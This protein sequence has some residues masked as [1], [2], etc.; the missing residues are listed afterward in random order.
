ML[1]VSQAMHLEATV[2]SCT[3]SDVPLIFHHVAKAGGTSLRH[4]LVR[5]MSPFWTNPAHKAQFCYKNH[6]RGTAN[7]SECILVAEH[8]DVRGA[9]ELRW[10]PTLTRIARITMLRKPRSQF[11]S[12]WAYARDAAVKFHLPLNSNA[13]PGNASCGQAALIGLDLWA[14]AA[15]TRD[16]RGK[17]RPSGSLGYLHGWLGVAGAWRLCSNSQRR[18]SQRGTRP[19]DLRHRIVMCALDTLAQDFDVVG[20][21]EDQTTFLATLKQRF[22]YLRTIEIPHVNEGSSK[23]KTECEASLRLTRGAET[24]FETDPAVR[25]HEVLY[26]GAR[27]IADAQRLRLSSCARYV[28][29]SP[30][31]LQQQI[32][33]R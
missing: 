25:L 10:M 1:R 29:G 33:S 13:Q 24:A 15:G 26:A 5:A 7:L 31:R 14:Q 16:K 18:F 11:V 30:R 2:S 4:A 19:P 32:S 21:Y 23:Y 6:H 12:F 3:R 20:F 8:W 17:L 28:S 9:D 22:T 27:E